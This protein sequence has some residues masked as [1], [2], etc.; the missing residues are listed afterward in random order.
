[1]KV[2]GETRA[3]DLLV[4]RCASP[5]LTEQLTQQLLSADDA[6][7]VRIVVGVLFTHDRVFAV[8]SNRSV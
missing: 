6:L 8:F 2:L 5:H 7:Y 3:V 1:V 4:A